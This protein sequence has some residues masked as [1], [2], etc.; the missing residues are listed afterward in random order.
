MNFKQ[1]VKQ[2]QDVI[3]KSELAELLK[4][5]WGLIEWQGHQDSP[6]AG[7]ALDRQGGAA[8]HLYTGLESEGEPLAAVKSVLRE[9]GLFVL[10][11]AAQRGAEIW[12]KKLDTPTTDQINTA[13]STLENPDLRKTCHTYADALDHYPS[14]GHSVD[15]LVYINL[16]NALLANNIDFKD[17]VGVD[18]TTWGPTTA[19]AKKQRYHS[20]IPLVSAYAPA[21]V[22]NDYGHALAAMLT[23]NLGSVLDSSVAFALRGIIQRVVRIASPV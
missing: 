20:L 10:A 18:I 16:V 6:D 9:F 13:R 14:K 11:R 2:S 3:E 7:A 23:D 22:Y 17:S 21:A 12:A 15:R 5:L 19:Y 4:P 1:I 8:I